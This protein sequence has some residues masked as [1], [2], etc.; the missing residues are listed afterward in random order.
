MNHTPEPW[1]KMI[2]ENESHHPIAE[3]NGH[4]RFVDLDKAENAD[5]IVACVN[6]MQGIEDPAEFVRCADKLLNSMGFID[7]RESFDTQKEA[8]S[9]FRKSRGK[10]A[11]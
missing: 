5:R 6:A 1:V 7:Q 10:D 8:M 3:G 9:E 4:G 2:Y 11:Q